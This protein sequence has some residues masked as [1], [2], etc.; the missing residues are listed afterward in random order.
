M[1]FRA[2]RPAF[3]S[4]SVSEGHT[5]AHC[6]QDVH[7]FVSTNPG[8]CSTVTLKSPAWPFNPAIFDRVFI[9]IFLFFATSLMVGAS[10]HMEQSSVSLSGEN[11]FP[12]LT[13]LTPIVRLFSIR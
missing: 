4:S 12:I 3:H 1:A 5:E 13:M 2:Q 8:S 7:F 9:S 10:E 11:T 6:P